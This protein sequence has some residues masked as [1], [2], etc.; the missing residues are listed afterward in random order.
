MK[1][2]LFTLSVLA[3]ALARPSQL[4]E[5]HETRDVFQTAHFTFHGGPASYNLEVT[6][7][8]VEV[9]TSIS[10]FCFLK[11]WTLYRNCPNNEQTTT[12]LSI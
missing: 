5:D 10:S 4:V 12:S 2:A 11:H 1:L 9:L 3:G 7:N 8:G 6:A